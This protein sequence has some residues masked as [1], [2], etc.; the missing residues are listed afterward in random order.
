MQENV[1]AYVTDLYFR[2]LGDALTWKAKIYTNHRL[3]EAWAQ[4]DHIFRQNA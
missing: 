1:C 3:N 4:S 2:F